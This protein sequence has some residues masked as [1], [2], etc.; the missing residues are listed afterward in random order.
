MTCFEKNSQRASARIIGYFVK[1]LRVAIL[2]GVIM[3]VFYN[4]CLSGTALILVTVSDARW[5][6]VMIPSWHVHHD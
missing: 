3:I 1:R 5:K 6:L 4:A 2:Q